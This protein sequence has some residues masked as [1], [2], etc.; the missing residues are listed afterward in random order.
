MRESAA[1][2]QWMSQSRSRMCGAAGQEFFAPHG[3]DEASIRMYCTGSPDGTI[4]TIKGFIYF[5]W[6]L[7]ALGRLCTT[8][9]RSWSRF[10]SG[11]GVQN[12][13]Y[14]FIE[15]SPVVS[16]V[17][18]HPPPPSLPQMSSYEVPPYHRL[19]N[20]GRAD[21]SKYSQ[22]L[23]ILILIL[24][25]IIPNHLISSLLSLFSSSETSC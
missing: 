12:R 14:Y 16:H 24:I 6:K 8:T 23:I 1:T 5:P 9:P 10:G 7:V 22:P 21:R 11:D 15:M 17:H 19:V 13:F 3:R 18:R 4:D 25:L 20:K 2:F